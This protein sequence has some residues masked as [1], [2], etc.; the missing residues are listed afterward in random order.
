MKHHKNIDLI[1]VP[2]QSTTKSGKNIFVYI[3]RSTANKQELSIQKQEDN[4]RETIERNG[5]SEAD[6]E[7]YIES[8]TAFN[9]VR[10]NDGKVVERRKEFNRMLKDIDASKSPVTILTY[11]HSRLSRNDYDTQA[12][13]DRLFNAYGDK[14]K[15][16]IEKIIFND[17]EVW[18]KNTRD[19]DV[20]QF[21]LRAYTE[22]EI[23]GYRASSGMERQLKNGRYVF[24]TPLGII[25]LAHHEDALRTDDKMPHIQHIWKM[26]ANLASNRE[27][28]EYLKEHNIVITTGLSKHFQSLIY[29]GYWLNEETGELVPQRFAWWKPPI[30]WELYQKVQNTLARNT[31][32]LSHSFKY[33]SKQEWWTIAKLLKWEEDKQKRFSLEKAKGK[34]ASYKSNAFWGFN[35]SERKIIQAFCDGPLLEIIKIYS[36]IVIDAKQTCLNQY[37]QIVSTKMQKISDEARK[38]ISKERLEEIEEYLEKDINAEKLF[39]EI[40]KDL[41]FLNQDEIW[42]N[43]M[44]I[45]ADDLIVRI[46][47]LSIKQAKE[48]IREIILKNTLKDYASD[49]MRKRNQIKK[50]EWEMEDAKKEIK[51]IQKNWLLKG[52]DK[53]IVDELV[54]DKQNEI[55]NIQNRIQDVSQDTEIESFIDIL[56]DILAKTLELSKKAFMNQDFEQSREDIMKLI[57]IT[58]FELSI[59]TK[60]ELRIKLFDWLASFEKVDFKLW[61]AQ[62]SQIRT[63]VENYNKVKEKY[64]EN[65]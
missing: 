36:K 47:N 26:K 19:S 52:Y 46:N 41:H 37:L 43:D 50:L 62:N 58:T 14:T 11:E 48:L 57:E 5:Y 49:R 12:V 35:M 60:K 54:Q 3:R 34:Y 27:I 13:L 25:R 20:K 56:P 17:W 7:Y 1:K 64:W 23:T 61:L 40:W 8:K 15:W 42:F 32:K 21:L 24:K 39:S 31:G 10:V 53:D 59:N 9:K 2:L 33:G 55:I 18:N 51:T 22:S 16:T 28:N 30:S 44:Q 38:K 63:F 45:Q 4:A 6:V 65:F 29:A